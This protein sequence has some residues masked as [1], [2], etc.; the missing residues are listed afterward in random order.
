MR[1]RLV[2]IGFLCTALFL[3]YSL[4]SGTYGLPRIL[5]LE[6]Q[7]DALV[8]ANRAQLAEL[9]DTARRRD[10]LLSDPNYIEYLA[11]TRFHM[12]FPNETVY[13]YRQR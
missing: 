6:L 11:R 3:I 13:R 7:R 9:V 10:L 12:A 1:R 4:V 2:S 5:K 8:A